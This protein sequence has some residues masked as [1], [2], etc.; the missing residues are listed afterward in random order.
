[1]S[2]IVVF[3]WFVRRVGRTGR[4]VKTWDDGKDRP[5]PST[6]SIVRWPYTT[7]TPFLLPTSHSPPI[8]PTVHW[9]HLTL[10][11]PNDWVSQN[12]GSRPHPPPPGGL[13][14][15]RDISRPTAVTY[16]RDIHKIWS[17]RQIAPRVALIPE[18]PPAIHPHRHPRIPYS[19]W[20]RVRPTSSSSRDSRSPS[21]AR[22]MHEDEGARLLAHG[23][24]T[25]RHRPILLFYSSSSPWIIGSRTCALADPLMFVCVFVF[26]FPLLGLCG[27]LFGRPTRSQKE[28]AS[29]RS[30]LP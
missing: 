17:A 21:S 23:L 13:P 7:P 20:W 6:P 9:L 27:S 10:L 25:R 26:L 15:R 4:R 5:S 14:W 18:A 16:D 19:A 12:E 24:A 3:L 29:S 22:S 11:P 2:L 8:P 30:T 28:R 1:M